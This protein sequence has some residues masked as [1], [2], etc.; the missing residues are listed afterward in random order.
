[1]DEYTKEWWAQSKMRTNE[2]QQLLNAV[3]QND[4]N[5]IR[6]YITSGK[7]PL[8]DGAINGETLLHRATKQ[9]QIA[10]MQLLIDAGVNVN[11]INMPQKETPLHIAICNS[12]STEA[13]QQLS[14]DCFHLLLNHKVDLNLKTDFG[15]T[16]LHLAVNR[17][18]ELYVQELLKAGAHV[19]TK[20]NLP[21]FSPL[22]TASERGDLSIVQM[23]VDYGADIQA[24]SLFG[25]T[26]FDIAV[27]NKHHDVVRYLNEMNEVPIKSAL[28]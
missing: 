5:T 24:R 8:I 6:T 14:M 9:K 28:D 22:H 17:G 12:A 20:D 2:Y 3:D 13:L 11:A 4:L 1:M 26:S 18:Y 25:S 23:L 7:L 10:C 21:G 16:P 27:H 15:L 19:Q